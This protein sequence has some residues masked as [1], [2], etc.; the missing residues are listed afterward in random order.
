MRFGL[1]CIYDKLTGYMVPAHHQN[2]NQA[3]RAFA[4]DI[5]NAGE[6]IINANVGDFA[7]HRVGY[8]DTETGLIESCKIEILADA[9]SLLRKE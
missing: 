9:G 4:Y 8:F 7:L 3:I 5:N 6:N 2:D 1:Y